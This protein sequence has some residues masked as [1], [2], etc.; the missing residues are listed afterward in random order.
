MIIVGIGLMMRR[1]LTD[2]GQIAI[3]TFE[4]VLLLVSSDVARDVYQH[5]RRPAMICNVIRYKQGGAA[6]GVAGFAC[7]AFTFSRSPLGFWPLV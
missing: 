2:A 7:K 4:R 6:G 1:R 3:Q 5:H